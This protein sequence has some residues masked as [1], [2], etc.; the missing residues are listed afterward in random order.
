MI[1]PEEPRDREA[2][3]GVERAAFGSGVEA[4]IVIGWSGLT[5]IRSALARSVAPP[6][7]FAARA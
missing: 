5:T 2:S 4:E 6:T 7:T 3:I 1:R